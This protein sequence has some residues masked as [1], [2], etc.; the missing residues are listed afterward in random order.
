M[1]ALVKDLELRRVNSA[2]IHY[3]TLDVQKGKASLKL[4]LHQHDAH[5]YGSLRPLLSGVDVVGK[6]DA[7]SKL[8][9]ELAAGLA[10][11]FVE[12]RK[13][14]VVLRFEKRG[15]G[16]LSGRLEVDDEAPGEL[17]EQASLER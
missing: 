6:R 4:A 10:A 8:G 16:E 15:R 3:A 13:G 1:N 11:H 17:G 12:K 14:K 5:L 9:P 7:H 2:L